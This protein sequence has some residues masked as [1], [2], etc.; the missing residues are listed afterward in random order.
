LACTGSLLQYTLFTLTV[1]PWLCEL[2]RRYP[3]A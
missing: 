1:T 3:G 2:Y